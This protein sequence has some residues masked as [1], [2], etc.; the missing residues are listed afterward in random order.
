M[1]NLW[2]SLYYTLGKVKEIE[3]VEKSLI[4][5][6]HI[7]SVAEAYYIFEFRAP[8]NIGELHNCK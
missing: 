6:L 4:I 2:L 5:T 7:P 8:T 1:V 3:L